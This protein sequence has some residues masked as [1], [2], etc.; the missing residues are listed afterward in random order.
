MIEPPTGMLKSILGLQAIDMPFCTIIYK[1]PMLT[2][3]LTQKEIAQQQHAAELEMF[4][5]RQW[6]FILT[7]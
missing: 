2:R 3:H 4:M 7:T 1:E 6:H 5:V